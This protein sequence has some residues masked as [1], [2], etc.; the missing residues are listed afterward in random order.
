MA[1]PYCNFFTVSIKSPPCQQF[2]DKNAITQT[3]MQKYTHTH[4]HI[5]ALRVGDRETITM[6][7]NVM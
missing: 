5:K 3:Q 7:T 6:E 4:T 1:V 2:I